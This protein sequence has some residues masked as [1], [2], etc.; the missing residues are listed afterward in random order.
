[1][2]IGLIGRKCGMTRVFRDG[3]SIPVTVVLITPNHVTQIK[4]NKTDGYNAIQVTAGIRKACRVNKPLLGHFSKAGVIGG[5]GLWEFRFSENEKM[6]FSL[7][8]EIK[9][10]IF[11]LGQKIDVSANSK[12]RGFAGVI[13]RHH[14]KS[15]RAT[16]GN[17]LAH[18]APGSIGQNQTPGKVFKGKKMAGQMG[19]TRI[20]IH[21]LV[22][23]RIIEEENLLLVRGAIPGSPGGDI[24]IRPAIK[25]K[26]HHTSLNGRK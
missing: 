13:R 10:S 6:N 21:N 8:H 16:H 15:Q 23:V 12:G 11:K 5:R 17:S 19:N 2:P 26:N 9:V 3:V 20:T 18:N 7:G 4:T 1:M 24:M 25:V 14:F 22:V